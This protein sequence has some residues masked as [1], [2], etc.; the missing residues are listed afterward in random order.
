MPHKARLR[1]ESSFI[2]YGARFAALRCSLYR[3]ISDWAPNDWSLMV[4]YRPFPWRST[5][6]TK[7]RCTCIPSYFFYIGIVSGNAV[8]GRQ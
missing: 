7:G 5:V 8:L 3:S 4:H 6:E 2:V 1:S